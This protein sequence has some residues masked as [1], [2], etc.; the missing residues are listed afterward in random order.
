MVNEIS[1]QNRSPQL[2]SLAP[3]RVQSGPGHLVGVL[4]Q[5]SIAC[6]GR[7]LLRPISFRSPG[8]WRS[9]PER[10]GRV[11]EAWGTEANST[12]PL[13][14]SGLRMRSNSK[15]FSANKTKNLYPEQY[16]SIPPLTPLPDSDHGSVRLGRLRC[17]CDA[18]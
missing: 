4:L 10:T 6:R 14:F 18:G 8:P 16:A 7:S 11:P 15:F 17:A 5:P 3:V 13:S 9:L 1:R 2:N 12:S